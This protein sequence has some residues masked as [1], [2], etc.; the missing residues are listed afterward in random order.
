MKPQG[1]NLDGVSDIAE[2]VE[3]VL[4]TRLS[5]VHALKGELARREK[6]GLHDF[7]IACKRLRYAL[8]RFEALNPAL[9]AAAEKLAL[10]QDALGEAHDRDVLLAILPTTMAATQ[11]RLQS[12]RE[13]CVDRAIALWAELQQSVQALDSHSI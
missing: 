7:R 3:R 11:R 12:E 1:V 8:E 2:L 10:L 6:Q 5:E 9:Q 4:Q 13:G